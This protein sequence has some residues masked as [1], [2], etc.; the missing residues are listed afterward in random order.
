MYR[1]LLG[2]FTMD[3]VGQLDNFWYDRY[4]LGVDSAHI[5]VLKES[6]QVS[7]SSFFKGLDG[8]I[9]EMKISL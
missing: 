5:G 1:R 8:R 3:S 2:L 6:D 7:L 9:L 4:M